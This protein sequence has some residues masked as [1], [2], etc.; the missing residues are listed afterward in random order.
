MTEDNKH[1]EN[2]IK[3]GRGLNRTNRY[4]DILPCKTVNY[5]FI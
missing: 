3:M 2:L 1:K 4:A 5:N